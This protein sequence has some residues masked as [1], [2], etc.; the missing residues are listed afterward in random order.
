VVVLVEMEKPL[1]DSMAYKVS[2]P[3]VSFPALKCRL[4]HTYSNFRI[5]GAM[6]SGFRRCFVKSLAP[7]LLL[8]GNTIEKDE[9]DKDMECSQKSSIRTT[10]FFM[11]GFA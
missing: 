6:L 3:S 10:R 1:V 9:G 8:L 7:L 5:A 4:V 2:F 11:V